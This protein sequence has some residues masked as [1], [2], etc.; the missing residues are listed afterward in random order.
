MD[1]NA[2]SASLD[3]CVVSADFVASFGDPHGELRL[4][5]SG[6]CKAPLVDLGVVRLDGED[7]RDFCHGQFTSDCRKLTPDQAQLSAWCNPKGRVLFLF[8]VVMR[9]DALFVLISR[10]MLDRFIARLRMFVL[11]AQVTIRDATADLAVL[12][13]SGEEAATGI[14]EWSLGPATNRKLVLG[15]NAEIARRWQA[16][17]VPAVGTAAWHA[18]DIRAGL[19]RLEPVLAAEF[20][21]QNLNLDFLAGLSFDKG[22][23]PGQEVIARL[24]YRG[25]VKSRL[26]IGHSIA[27]TLPVA[28]TRLYRP[29]DQ[30]TSSAGQVVN[31]AFAADGGIDVLAVVDLEA[32]S[33]LLH[34]D[35][36]TGATVQ[37]RKPGYWLDQ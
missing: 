16:C 13:L 25:Q 23:Y 10:N 1:S 36:P 5:T 20:L 27:E 9:D 18:L 24:K 29:D 22:C 21:P 2:L 26:Q 14:G 33:G 32:A 3:H 15:S 11:R 19:P 30:S 4:A 31:A 12:G 35:T 34:L 6:P 37:F 28:G 17:P 7:A 8:W